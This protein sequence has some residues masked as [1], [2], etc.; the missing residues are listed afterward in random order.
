MINLVEK[1]TFLITRILIF[2][3]VIKLN[4]I[5]GKRI[6]VDILI[7]QMRASMKYLSTTYRIHNMSNERVFIDIFVDFFDFDTLLLSY[8]S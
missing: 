6:A 3:N 1:N 4:S 7:I 2:N 8:G 5:I